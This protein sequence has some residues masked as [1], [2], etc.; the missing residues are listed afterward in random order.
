MIGGNCVSR[1]AVDLVQLFWERRS[2]KT[3]AR[4]GWLVRNGYYVSCITLAHLGYKVVGYGCLRYL[5]RKPTPIPIPNNAN[6]LRASHCWRGASPLP[7]SIEIYLLILTITLFTYT[8]PIVSQCRQIKNV[9]EAQR[10]IPCPQHRRLHA[11]RVGRERVWRRGRGQRWFEW[12]R[13]MLKRR[14]RA[15]LWERDGWK[16][17]RGL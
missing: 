8:V 4:L 15:C 3:W 1:M 12:A 7:Q 2:E 16:E 11:R 10:P 6:T 14:G 9:R 17:D 5:G 13:G